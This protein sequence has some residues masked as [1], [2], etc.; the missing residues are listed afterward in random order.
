MFI[1]NYLSMGG[2]WFELH[3]DDYGYYAYNK[4]GDCINNDHCKTLADLEEFCDAYSK[5]YD[6]HELV[7]KVE[8]A[9]SVDALNDDELHWVCTRINQ[10]YD[11]YEFDYYE[12]WLERLTGNVKEYNWLE[13]LC[14]DLR[15]LL[16]WSK[17]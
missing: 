9:G 12:M 1:M 15:N 16:E 14:T 17:C 7:L 11:N 8:A 3:Q 10:F 2:E 5:P 13:D 4:L 6:F